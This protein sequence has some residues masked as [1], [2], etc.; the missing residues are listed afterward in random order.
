MNK[1]KERSSGILRLLFAVVV[2]AAATWP[3]LLARDLEDPLLPED[4]LRGSGPH[5]I[6]PLFVS[7]IGVLTYLLMGSA[8]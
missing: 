3:A 6:D 1:S 2:L 8:R 4:V 7:P 5:R